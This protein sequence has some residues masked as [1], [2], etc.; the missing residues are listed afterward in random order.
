[1]MLRPLRLMRA[2]ASLPAP[3]TGITR[4]LLSGWFD[5][6]IPAD[7]EE[8]K[9]AKEKERKIV[10]SKLSRSIFA[11]LRA[12]PNEK[13][14][15]TP[16]LAPPAPFPS[17]TAFSLGDDAEISPLVLPD[18][19]VGSRPT[20][21]TLSF[22]ALGQAQAKKWT[23]PF[24]EAFSPTSVPLSVSERY[25]VGQ[26]ALLQLLYL[27]G[28]FFNAMRRVF[29][30]SSRR[31]LDASER[32]FHGIVFQPSEKETDVSTRCEWSSP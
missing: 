30:T 14:I 2:P 1:M 12:A 3:F 20:L 27:E 16:I 17:C 10:M 6:L 31:A 22:Q 4:R 8:T 29:V 32:P 7:D 21:V 15:A 18:S 26:P 13:T 24:L 28:F 19:L 9:A 25:A 5:R 23:A 11:E